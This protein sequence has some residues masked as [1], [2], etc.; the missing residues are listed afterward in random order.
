MIKILLSA[1]ILT[2]FNCRAS[3][4]GRSE[5]QFFD[6]V[7]ILDLLPA[8]NTLNEFFAGS[9]PRTIIIKRKEFENGN[10]KFNC[11]TNTILI[12]AGISDSKIVNSVVA[13]EAT[14]IALCLLTN[15]FNTDEK[16]RFWDEG[17]ATII[18]YRNSGREASYKRR[19]HELALQQDSQG[20]LKFDK[21]Q[22]WRTYS[23]DKHGRVNGYAY[24]V[25]SSFVYFLIDSFGED[26]FKKFLLE[27]GRTENFEETVNKIFKKSPQELEDNW[28]SY[29]KEV[30]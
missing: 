13:H 6:G 7:K 25:G 9:M 5:F 15:Q 27:I 16:S 20:N 4:M 22:N 2:G 14:H 21:L 10:S 12:N 17:L 26:H 3:E 11:A 29:L 1:F 28:R 18:Q 24:G 19:S 23:K 8:W 30:N